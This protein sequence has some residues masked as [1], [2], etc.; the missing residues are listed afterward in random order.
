MSKTREN[1]TRIL[2]EPVGMTLIRL[3]VPMIFGILSMVIYNLTDTFYVGR[4]GRE[5]LAALSF[6]FPVVLT[7]ASLAQGIGMGAAAAVSRAIGGED[8]RRVRRLAADSLVLGLL[9]VGLGALVG[10]L[11][12][13]PLFSLLGARGTV[14]EYTGEYMRVWY[15]GMVFV[16][17]PMVGNSIIR[18]TGDT[19]TPGLIMMLGALVNFIMDPLLIFGIGPFPALGIRGAAIAT[20]CGR[21]FTFLTAMYVLVV[22]EK[23]LAFEVP[24]IRELLASW[25]EVMHVGLPNAGTRMIIPL[26]NGFITRVIAGYGAA[27]V[28]GY[29]V[30]TRIEFF[31]LAALNALAAVIGPFIGQNLGA[32][33]PERVRTGFT[34]S[35][36]FSLLA[37]GGLFLLY[38]PLAGRIAAV[39]NADPQVT[40]AAAL[41]L[42][43]VSAAYAAQG[44]YLVAAAGLNVLRRPFEAA[45]LSLLQMFGLSVPLAL[46]GSRVYGIPGVFAAV[47]VS[48]AVTGLVSILAVRKAVL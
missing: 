37:G 44:F 31:S 34:V 35:G 29:G 5:Q 38:L 26:G 33:K 46:L 45:G 25:R 32:G 47:G 23:L 43:I 22:R 9:V 7:V 6:T 17:V 40:A 15:V 10:R 20:V 2:E 28:A 1:R 39:F 30:A 11:T 12:I 13:G 16:V 3:T 42:R 48:Y 19:K 8:Y 36:Y 14:L 41:Y 27:A 21:S 4:L 18:A 24:R